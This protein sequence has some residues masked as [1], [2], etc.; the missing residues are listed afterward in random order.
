LTASLFQFN[1]LEDRLRKSA[2]L[3]SASGFC[4]EPADATLASEVTATHLSFAML[5]YFILIPFLDSITNY[6]LSAGENVRS[7]H[8]NL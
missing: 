5:T 2:T 6:L 7:R 3:F 4:G 1:Y 8:G